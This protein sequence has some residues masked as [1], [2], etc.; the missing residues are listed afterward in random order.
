MIE[1]L[2][3][4]DIESLR[5]NLPCVSNDLIN[6]SQNEPIRGIIGNKYS[7]KYI[8]PF[9]YEL[10]DKLASVHGIERENF[11]ITAGANHGI[12]ICCRCFLE[13]GDAC[14]IYEP[15]YGQYYMISSVN[16][17]EMIKFQLNEKFEPDWELFDKSK[18]KMVF[19]SNP[20]NPT[21]NLMS[22]DLIEEGLGKGKVIVVDEAYAE[23]TDLTAIDLIE[24]YENLVVLRTFSKVWSIPGARVGYTVANKRTSDYLELSHIPFHMSNM[25]VKLA[26]D[27]LDHEEE[28]WNLVEET[29]QMRENIN[30][31]LIAL[32]L[33]P[34]PSFTN[35]ILVKFPEQ[36]DANEVYNKLVG[37]GIIISN[38][39]RQRG[40]ENCL[41]VSVGKKEHNETFLKALGEI[42]DDWTSE[43]NT[44]I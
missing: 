32:G 44:V 4:K 7:S 14:A 35:F 34:Y 5:F 2:V 3:R 27:A 23:Y 43:F 41:R 20:N 33:H 18:A 1:K 29:T 10:K 38:V 24:S 36:V 28:M 8:G 11:V 37:R 25:A 40:I 22:L 39:S 9:Y 31:G 16:G 17:R 12:D 13:P 21:G 26:Y 19:L 30:E 6:L 15:T 42:L